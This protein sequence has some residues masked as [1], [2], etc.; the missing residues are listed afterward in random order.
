MQV[1]ISTN[2]RIT[3]PTK[4][5]LSFLCGVVAIVSLPFHL[6]YFR[7]DLFFILVLYASLF[8]DETDFSIWDATLI[9]IFANLFY[10]VIFGTLGMIFATV[11]SI[12]K[13]L[14]PSLKN[15]DSATM[16]VI[17]IICLIFYQF[18]L[19]FIYIHPGSVESISVFLSSI[20]SNFICWLVISNFKFKRS[21]I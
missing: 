2:K 18:L 19:R 21:K 10:P 5:F 11:Y 15:I 1:N 17:I 13:I 16:S 6:N 4:V 8:I 9:G 20:L 7:P 3:I 12:F 14:L